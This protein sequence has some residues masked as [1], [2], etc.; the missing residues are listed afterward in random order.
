MSAPKTY[1]PCRRCRAMVRLA[2]RR[3][4]FCGA[5]VP[6]RWLPAVVDRG[7]RARWL[8]MGFGG[9]VGTALLAMT[10]V[11]ALGN[12]SDLP[13][14]L[15]SALVWLAGAIGAVAG[16]S[17]GSLV[18]SFIDENWLHPPGP[19]PLAAV[20]AHLGQRALQLQTA[21]VH[22]DSSRKRLRA[23]LSTD[24]Q[25]PA[26]AALD[27]AERA[28]RTQLDRMALEL[29]RAA[30]LRWQNR[31]QPID[32]GLRLASRDQCEA[33]LTDLA[34]IVRDGEEMQHQQLEAARSGRSAERLRA[35]I[36][37]L[38]AACDALRR[39]LLLRQAAALAEAAPG[40]AAAFDLRGLVPDLTGGSSVLANSAELAHLDDMLPSLEEEGRR[41]DSE[42]AAIE[43]VGGVDD[44]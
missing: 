25:A 24:E 38:L 44:P 43:A 3:C 22:V 5:G 1:A 37:E 2:A 28:T 16:L 19:R 40:V 7:L 11:S 32:A 6:A 17:V 21:L 14:F 31:L 35:R 33:W 4:D 9:M 42:L 23:R 10:A 15:A 36:D 26:L 34:H 30:L 41:L 27:A 20:E 18:G 39:G 29:E 13:P 8:A 12:G